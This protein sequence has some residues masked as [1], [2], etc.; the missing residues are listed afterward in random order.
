MFTK[1]EI[2]TMFGA[3]LDGENGDDSPLGVDLFINNW[4]EIEDEY[5][6]LFLCVIDDYDYSPVYKRIFNISTIQAE[7]MCEY[8]P[9]HNYYEYSKIRAQFKLNNNL[10]EALSMFYKHNPNKLQQYKQF[11]QQLK[12]S[13]EKDMV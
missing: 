8:A 13:Y 7:Q 11:K 2:E 5:Q 9:L 1:S 4:S 3:L 12:N 6:L 10:D